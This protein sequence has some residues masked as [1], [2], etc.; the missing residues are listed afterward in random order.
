MNKKCTCGATHPPD[1]ETN[2]LIFRVCEETKKSLI[3]FITE[4]HIVHDSYDTYSKLL[5]EVEDRS[6]NPYLT[7]Q[8]QQLLNSFKAWLIN[9]KITLASEGKAY[10]KQEIGTTN[11]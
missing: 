3:K 2:E 8:Q 11:V 4:N 7:E 9:R 5:D 1:K 6:K 10:K